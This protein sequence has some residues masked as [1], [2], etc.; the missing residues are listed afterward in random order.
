MLFKDGAIETQN[1]HIYTVTPSTRMTME[2]CVMHGET[3][4]NPVTI[5]YIRSPAITF[6]TH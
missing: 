5:S 3:C 6:T 1:A 4:E 2:C